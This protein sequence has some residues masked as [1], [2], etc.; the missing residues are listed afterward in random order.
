MKITKLYTLAFAIMGMVAASCSDD[1][2]TAY[3]TTGYTDALVYGFKLPYNATYCSDSINNYHFTID[4]YGERDTLI[5]IG[6]EEVLVGIGRIYNADSLPYGMVTSSLLAEITFSSPDKVNL[7]MAGDKKIE[8]YSSTDSIDFTSPVMMEVIAGNGINKKFYEVKVN[9]H[10]QVGDSIDW[11]FM[12]YPLLN[13][14]SISDQRS[15]V[16]GNTAVWMVENAGAYSVYTSDKSLKQWTKSE[17]TDVT[18]DIKTLNVFKGKFYVV[19]KDG[20]LY[21]SVNGLSW[22]S[23]AANYKFVNI[24]GSA[25]VSETDNRLLALVEES[26][27]VY[28]AYS[29]NGADW[30]K[31]DAVKSN[32]PLSGYSEIASYSSP[33]TGRYTS[34]IFGGKLQSGDLTSDSWMY[35]QKEG[36]GD[37]GSSTV[38]AMQ[39]ANLVSYQQDP[40]YLN[41][42][43]LDRK[44]VV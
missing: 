36:W 44:S 3:D 13:P 43:W 38:R 21:S 15:A 39:G 19:S 42:F 37:M 26:G 34:V 25:P 23:V 18:P 7:Y 27:V 2:N 5:K 22:T 6:S 24:I 30:V 41:T 11:K 14:G 32:F 17:L 12:G 40:R 28:H 20:E 35:N 8:D 1:N 10:Q 16:C 9:V 31:E 33:S 4:N 29:D